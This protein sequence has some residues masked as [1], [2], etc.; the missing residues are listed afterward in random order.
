L[1]QRPLDRFRQLAKG[2]RQGFDDA[3]PDRDVP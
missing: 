2:F 3:A 1:R